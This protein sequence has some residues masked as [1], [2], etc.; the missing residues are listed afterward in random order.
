MTE[1]VVLIGCGGIGNQLLDPLCRYLAHRPEP[2]PLL[3]LVDGDVFEA[4][5]LN[6]QACSRSDLGTNKAEAL[7]RVARETGV[8]SQAIGE[9]VDETNVGVIVREGDIVLLAVD[10]HRAR[11]LIDRHVA[12]LDNATLISGGNDETDGNVQLVRRRD[13]WSVDG[14]LVEIHPEANAP[15]P[16]E[17]LIAAFSALT[18]ALRDTDRRGALL[19]LDEAHLLADDRQR[20]RFPL[21]SLLAALGRVQR[22]GPTVRVVLSGLPTLSLNLKRARTYAE[23]MFRHVVIGNLSL[24]AATDAL[25][26]PLAGSGRTFSL[27]LIGHIVEE[28]AGYP[29][30]LQ[31]AGA[32]A[33][34]RI[35]LLHIERTHFD[36]VQDALL[37][38]LDL[39]FFEDRFEGAAPTEQALLLAMA[40]AGGR[41]TL[42]RIAHEVGPGVNAA[43]G[44]RRPIDKGLVYRPTRATYDFAL[45]LFAGYLGRRAKVTGL[46]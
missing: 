27:G 1:R 8:A 21:S 13:G 42:T 14:H 18:K 44:L 15:A 7:A 20:E 35:G 38:E 26:V 32:F 10:N 40:R 41:A 34:S 16:T 37:H 19:L 6:R 5:N 3:V 17:A 11:A 45:P 36:R 9:L 24:A 12:S 22:E 4:S 31:F 25:A 39:A 46:S 2:R 43:V 30:F 29:Y 33:C 23:R 28:T